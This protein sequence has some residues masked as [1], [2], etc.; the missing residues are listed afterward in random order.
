MNLF[1]GAFDWGDGSLSLPTLEDAFQRL[2][3]SL[4]VFPQPSPNGIVRCVS[5][6]EVLLPSSNF[7]KSTHIGLFFMPDDVSSHDA[8]SL[9]PY[10]HVFL[11][12]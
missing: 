8:L 11:R 9:S 7:V 3:F 5:K 10:G 6:C 12:E 2:S 4:H 1:F